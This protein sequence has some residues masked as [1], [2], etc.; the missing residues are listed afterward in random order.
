MPG[1]VLLQLADAARGDGA[2]LFNVAAPDDALRGA[3]CRAD[4]INVAPSRA[5]LADAVAQYL[6]WKRWTRWLLVRGSHPEDAAL[7]DAYRRAAKRFGAR[8][9][10]ER[11]FKDTGE[12]RQTDSGLVL[13]QQQMPVFTQGAPRLRRAGGGRR[14]RGVRGLPALSHLGP[15]PGRRLR[16]AAAGELGRQ[17]RIPGAGRSCRTASSAPSAAA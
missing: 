1:A 12:S 6:V 16:R 7:A 14:E 3:E 17:R 10:Q 2:T 15:P 5:M 8:I 9:V 13:T 11:V 4:I